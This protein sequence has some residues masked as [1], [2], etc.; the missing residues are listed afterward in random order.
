MLIRIKKAHAIMPLDITPKDVYLNRRTFM[1]GAAAAPFLS[2]AMAMAEEEKN[3]MPYDGHDLK[4]ELTPYQAVTTY[5]NFY[6]FGTNKDDPSNNSGSLITNPWTVKVDGHVNKP[7]DYNLE[8]LIKSHQM[9]ERIYRMRCVEAWSMVI[10]WIGIPLKDMIARFEPTSKAKYVRF[11]TL[12]D[13]D[14]M[15]GQKRRSIKWPYEEGLRMDE[16][17]NPLT[18]MAVGLYGDV[19]PNQNGA[20]I[21]LVVPW[22]YG[23]KGI[24]SI[25]RISFVEKK[26]KTSWNRL[27]SNEYGFY[28]NVNPDVDHPRWSQ[29]KERRIG[30]FLRRKTLMFNGYEEE[31]AHL[32]TGMN[33][34][35]Y[36]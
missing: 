31:V 27:A 21:R 32:Y 28:A 19:L 24:K 4:G 33:L 23:F 20:P 22:K 6:E 35:R 12:V 17:M 10:P 16:A 25:V 29:A 3:V 5:N 15:P 14:Q 30:D 1:M 2:P 9:E 7:G 8:D 18:L 36:Y 13:K 11:E 34:R 26:P